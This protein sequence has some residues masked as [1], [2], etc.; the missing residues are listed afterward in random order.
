MFIKKHFDP[1]KKTC[2]W[3]FQKDGVSTFSAIKF[4]AGDLIL[5]N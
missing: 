2:V 3:S 5:A 4:H 1:E